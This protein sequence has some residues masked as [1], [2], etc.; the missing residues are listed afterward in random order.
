MTLHWHCVQSS[1]GPVN[2]LCEN[3]SDNCLPCWYLIDTSYNDETVTWQWMGAKGRMSLSFPLTCFK[4]GR[5]L[6]WFFSGWGLP[7]FWSF[8][9]R[10][11]SIWLWY[12]SQKPIEI[13]VGVASSATRSNYSPR[14]CAFTAVWLW[15]I[16]GFVPT[17]HC[18]APWQGSG[19]Q[20]ALPL[21][22]ARADRAAG[23][24][25]GLICQTL[26]CCA[27]KWLHDIFVSHRSVRAVAHLNGLTRGRLPSWLGGGWNSQGCGQC[28]LGKGSQTDFQFWSTDSV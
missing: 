3:L 5:F 4:C 12:K 15:A 19:S 22:L 14:P 6:A 7:W 24:R 13:L 10:K 25:D 28:Y 17:W 18:L 20:A 26:A 21:F 27:A 2:W 9:N 8:W 16:L 1:H 11:T 23:R